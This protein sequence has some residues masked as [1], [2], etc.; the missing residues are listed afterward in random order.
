[1]S[2]E[3]RPRKPLD[4]ALGR[5]RI[6]EERRQKIIIGGIENPK[7]VLSRAQPS[8]VHCCIPLIFDEKEK[9]GVT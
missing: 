8:L 3:S 1:L 9:S 7:D 5:S 2:K 6:T 4:A